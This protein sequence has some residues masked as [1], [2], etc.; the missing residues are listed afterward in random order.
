M[1]RVHVDDSL[2]ITSSRAYFS[3]LIRPF[4]N[5]RS[6]SENI[7][8]YGDFPAWIEL[9]SDLT[10]ADVALLPMT[11]N[12]YR[13]K[14]HIK[15]AKKYAE[16]ASQAGVPLAVFVSGDY[17][18]YVDLPNAFVFGTSMYRSRTSLNQRNYAYASVFPDIVLNELGGMFDWR[19][20]VQI[21]TVG[22]CGQASTP[23]HTLLRLYGRNSVFR[24]ADSL[25]ILGF[26][27]P[28]IEPHIRLRR[29]ALDFL[30][31][32]NGI[33]ANFIVRDQYW[34]GHSDKSSLVNSA[35]RQEYLSNIMNSD[36]IVCIRGAG[37]YSKRFYESLCCGR[38]PVFVNTDCVLPYDFAVNY[39]DYCVW[40]EADEL[41]VIGERIKDFHHRL[42]A[43]QFGELQH[44]CR[45]L[46][47]EWLT[48]G[49]YLKNFH[50]HFA[51]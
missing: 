21:P 44:A 13:D 33:E 24:V 41:Q 38:I 12:Y 27:S 19:K 6:L 29:R 7:Q 37:N 23:L 42:S 40:V 32:T 18:P 20:K 51:D 1:L 49:G 16:L 11:W 50:R 4:W 9:V 39:R 45:D 46:W 25:K 14:G 10:E 3:E 31:R 8:I 34:G 43:S 22:F 48:F 28:P 47:L 5:H 2:G 17:S 30:S 15:A 35:V 36:Y 26:P